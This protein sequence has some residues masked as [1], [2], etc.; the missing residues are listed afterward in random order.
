MFIGVKLDIGFSENPLY[1][2]L[3]GAREVLDYLRDLGFTAVETPIGLETE[4]EALRSHIARCYEAGFQVSLHPYCEGTACD[5]TFFSMEL[6]NPCRK[7]H[8]RFLSFTAEISRIQ[9][10]PT[11]VNIHPG[12]GVSSMT[13]RNLVDR[14]IS[15]LSW[16]REWCS[17][18][19]PGIQIVAELQIGPDPGEPIQRMGDTYDE[20]LEIV[21]RSAVPA[22]WDFGH[23]YLNARRFGM[24]LLPPEEL[25]HRIGHVHCHDVCQGDHCPLIYDTL[26]WRDF[27][28]L[29][30]QRDYDNTIIMIVEQ[31]KRKT[32]I[33]T[34]VGKGIET[35][36]A[37]FLKMRATG[38]S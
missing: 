7:H 1:H 19:A 11:I 23:A 30:V 4:H 32:L 36:K 27:I 14:S 24:P 34:C 21:T 37:Q 35:D 38:F 20:L 6:D 3:Y 15:F 31:A 33:A 13:R 28:R 18:N 17:K 29:L 26:P 2:R 22:C 8:E 10:F 25:L 9:P 5:T 12:S 16:A